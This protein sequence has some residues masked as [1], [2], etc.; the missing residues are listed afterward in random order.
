M[1]NDGLQPAVLFDPLG[2]QALIEAARFDAVRRELT[3]LAAVKEL[4]GLVME[5]EHSRSLRGLV[6]LN[7]CAQVGWRRPVMGGGR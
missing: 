5:E 2:L 6:L 1:T 7:A 3:A 4:V